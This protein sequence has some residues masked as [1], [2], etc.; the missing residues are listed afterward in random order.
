MLELLYSNLRLTHKTNFH[1]AYDLYKKYDS[2]V[3][4]LNSSIVPNFSP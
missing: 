4:L 1:L 3:Q 2:S